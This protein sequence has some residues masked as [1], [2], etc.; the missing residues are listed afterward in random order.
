MISKGEHVKEASY[1]QNEE[2]KSSAEYYT[3]EEVHSEWLG[4]GSALD[5]KEIGGKVD[6][7]DFEKMLRGAVKDIDGSPQHFEE[8]SDRL[9]KLE[10]LKS[11]LG[12]AREPAERE[13][14]EAKIAAQ[15]EAVE[16]SL[17]LAESGERQLGRTIHF[18]ATAADEKRSM[19]AKDFN[20]AAK[21]AGLDADQ[22]E[23]AKEL[24]T[25]DGK[26]AAKADEKTKVFVKETL[27][28][29]GWEVAGFEKGVVQAKKTDHRA[30]W[31]FTVSESKSVSIARVRAMADG[32]T[33]TVNVFDEAFRAGIKAVVDKME[34]HAVA[35]IAGERV[36]T[37][38][39]KIALFEHNTAREGQLKDG[40]LQIDPGRHGHLILANQTMHEGKWFALETK[41]IFSH[42]KLEMDRAFQQEMA[43]HLLKNGIDVRFD[44]E[45][46]LEVAG[47]TRDQIE[48]FSTR[49]AQIAENLAKQGLTRE[50]ADAFQKQAATLAGRRDKSMPDAIASH[51][52]GWRE[53]MDAAG[54]K[55]IERQDRNLLT[56]ERLRDAAGIGKSPS[57]LAVAKE[58]R[59]GLAEL[60]PKGGEKPLHGAA[61]PKE[62]V[63]KAIQHLTS[64]EAAF[65]RKELYGNS[66]SFN[67]GRASTA[68]IDKAIE[69]AKKSGDL[70]QRRDG[71]F[72][73]KEM[74]AEE[75]K[76]ADNLKKGVGAHKAVMTDKEFEVALKKFEQ[77]KQAE[78]VAKHQPALEKAIKSGD[79]AAADKAKKAIDEAKGFALTASQRAS[80]RMVLV[81]NHAHQNVQGL[82]GMGKT[83]S[84]EFIKEAAERKGW[85]IQGFSNGSKQAQT[86]AKDSGIESSTTA[87]FLI[88]HQK[89]MRDAE[90]AEKALN[91]YD[92]KVKAPAWSDV[93][94]S[95]KAKDG[96]FKIERDQDGNR[97]ALDRKGNVFAESLIRKDDSLKKSQLSMFGRADTKY[98]KVVEKGLLFDKTKVFKTGGSQAANLKASVHEKAMEGGWLMRNTVGRLTK[99]NWEHVSGIEKFAVRAEMWWKGQNKLADSLERLEKAAAYK[100]S[101]SK[102]IFVMDEAGQSDIKEFNKVVK[103]TQEAGAKTLYQGDILQHGS[104]GANRAF[105]HAQRH[106]PTVHMTNRDEIRRQKNDYTKGVRDLVLDGRHGEAI[107][108]MTA[109]EQRGAQASLVG[110]ADISGEEMKKALAK[111]NEL[112]IGRLAKDYAA[113]KSGQRAETLVLTATNVDRALI[114]QGIRAELRAKW[115]LGE[116]RAFQTLSEAKLS[117]AQKTHAAFYKEGQAIKFTGDLKGLGIEK[118]AVA[119]IT[120]LDTRANK[121]TVRLDSGREV[122]F[123][124]SRIKGA[125]LYNKEQREF[126]EGDVI[127][128][129]KNDKGL[130]LQNGA[131]GVVKKIEGDKLHLE[132]AGNKELQVIDTKQYQHLDH[133]YVMTSHGAQGMSIDSAWIHH[134]VS[135][136]VHG[137]RQIYVDVTRAKEDL[138][139]YTQ[140]ADIAAKQVSN[141]MAKETASGP[142]FDAIQGESKELKAAIANKYADLRLAERANTAILTTEADRGGINAAIRAE[143]KD[144]GELVDGVAGRAFVR[145]ERQDEFKKGDYIRFN[146]DLRSLGARKYD[147]AEIIGQNKALGTVTIR[148]ENGNEKTF[149]PSAIKSKEVFRAEARE[150]AVGDKVAF[151]RADRGAGLRNHDTGKIVGIDGD[152]ATL[153]IDR[154]GK[155]VAVDLSQSKHMEYGYASTK[156]DEKDATKALLLHVDGGAALDKAT[157][158]TFFEASATRETTVFTTNANKV[159]EM[160]GLPA[161]REVKAVERQEQARE[162]TQALDAKVIQ[163]ANGPSMQQQQNWREMGR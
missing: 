130:D 9:V 112:L 30:G 133:G 150:F 143:L 77:R 157:A 73:T 70:I 47:I 62:A 138:R 127:R 113:L 118:G 26:G 60:A 17:S 13:R 7:A 87:S 108:A 97:F 83:V 23:A 1:Y 64:T 159:A 5:G 76:L 128:L 52:D 14:L 46:R 86:M 48:K 104:V 61:A 135:A 148:F 99:A 106:A 140:N 19:S 163:S 39:V 111:D 31:D 80:A 29:R 134:N 33:K 151:T 93:A 124:P 67:A 82:A 161:D 156:L 144:R 71:K 78:G 116:G 54:V 40:T 44:R 146:A 162:N 89:K 131:V 41:E 38:N 25:G 91:S 55:A 107:K 43:N 15:S 36:H 45:G 136:G 100:S 95:V 72:T 117:D 90:L 49:S 32:D 68:Q 56:G 147:Y 11:A 81:E 37:G 6:T 24:L 109:I 51:I 92:S 10:E 142:G 114:N 145:L 21:N 120:M 59:D 16:K 101:M 27:E 98:I 129:R 66:F 75:Q 8:L 96:R 123:D 119:E 85:S 34:Q 103:A 149:D 137:N 125:E 94:A 88:N 154:T 18:D 110:K 102:T 122:A 28:K 22:R 3:K 69:D 105:E 58:M 12:E 35:R 139:L 65:Q 2:G 155:E 132:M 153:R 50:T 63:S 57:P 126:A 84:L 20:A 74:V 160:T 115:E 152:I 4:T 79:V 53:R 121:I 141:G 42:R 158:R